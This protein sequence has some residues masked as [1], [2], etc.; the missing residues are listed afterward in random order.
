MG[1]WKPA[2]GVTVTVQEDGRVLVQFDRFDPNG[3]YDIDWSTTPATAS[4]RP[5]GGTSYDAGASATS[6]PSTA[7]ADPLVNSSSDSTGG[8]T[9]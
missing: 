8:T 9:I 2:K 5:N 4:F 3:I 7:T 1:D 6:S